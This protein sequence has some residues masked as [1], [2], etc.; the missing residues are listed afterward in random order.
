[1]ART[2]V[3]SRHGGRRAASAAVRTVPAGAEVLWPWLGGAAVTSL[4]TLGAVLLGASR[5]TAEIAALG[6]VLGAI[7]AAT[8]AM[9]TRSRASARASERDER[10]R[11][12]RDELEAGRADWVAEGASYVD[13]MAQWTGA[14]V[15]LLAHGRDAARSDAERQE[16]DAA[17]EDA[18][19]LN[20]LLEQSRGKQLHLTELATLHSLCGMWETNQGRVEQLAA[21]VDPAWH[22]RWGAQSLPAQRLRHGPP[23]APDRELPYLS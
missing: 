6:I 14:V 16:L 15:E 21:A 1:M 18:A 5:S 22:R 23:R 7:F 3:G 17:I 10:A 4:V 11:P 12:T 13:G 20:Q 9:T 19:A 8:V 2:E